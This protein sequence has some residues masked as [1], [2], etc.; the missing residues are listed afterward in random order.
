MRYIITGGTGLIGTALATDLVADRHE[1]IALSRTPERRGGLPEEVRVVGWDGRTAEGWG[2]LAEGAGAI[3]NL[4]GANL[5]G[6]GFLPSRWTDERKRIIRDSRVNSGRAVV[7]AV[8]QAGE[9]PRVLVQSSGVG[10]YG[11]RGDEPVTEE[12]DAGND[13]LARLA[14]DEW[15]PSTAS[16]E[17][18]GVRRVIIRTG[19]VLSSREGALPRLALPF[20]LFVGGTLGSGEQWHS[21]I[22]LRD[23]VR[24]IRFLVERE[25]ASGPFNFTAPNPA[26]NAEFGRTLGKV[27]NRP[28]WLPVPGFAMRLAFGQVSEVLLEGQRAV[29]WRL[30]ELGFEFRFPELEAALQDLLA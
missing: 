1:V 5:A 2:H 8:Q 10:Y 14:A 7:A 6:K 12:A 16:V 28:S 25:E 13:F 17:E 15:E 30:L 23:E 29:P 3:V 20:R 26:T 19:A 4:A 22:H 24:A 21:W 18:M 9:K 11:A 27:L